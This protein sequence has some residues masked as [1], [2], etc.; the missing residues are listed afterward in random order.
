VIRLEL[1]GLGTLC[2]DRSHFHQV[3]WNLL[4][5]RLR[6]SRHSAGSVR[7]LVRDA[8]TDGQVELHV[9]DDGPG[10]DDATR[11]RSSSRSSPHTVGGP[12]SGSTSHASCVTQMAAQLE[13]KDS[14]GRCRFLYFGRAV[15][16]QYRQDGSRGRGDKARVLVVDDEADI[17]ELL[18]LTL[19]RMGLAAD[20][21]GTVAEAKATLLE[22]ER[23]SCA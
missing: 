4:A 9:I 12:V 15:E 2:F 19:A 1:L 14:R 6:H 16:C 20:C 23:Y 13:L 3:L 5:T 11:N 18:D 21:A 10:V 7:L 8:Q 22:Q 17:R